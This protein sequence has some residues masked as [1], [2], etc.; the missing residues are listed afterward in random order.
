[1]F[2]FWECE[3]ALM[4]RRPLAHGGRDCL[5]EG[6]QGLSPIPAPRNICRREPDGRDITLRQGIH[7]TLTPNGTSRQLPIEAFE[8]DREC[9]SFEVNGEF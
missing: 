9:D 1:M 3:L 4:G 5:K 6:I 7:K 2:L 8:D